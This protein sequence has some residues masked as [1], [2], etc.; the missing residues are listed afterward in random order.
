M[1]ADRSQWLVVFFVL[2]T[3]I[4][5][6]AGIMWARPSTDW[7]DWFLLALLIVLGWAH[8]GTKAPE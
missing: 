4:P 3:A 1:T 8:I 2:L 5:L 7:L 6:Q